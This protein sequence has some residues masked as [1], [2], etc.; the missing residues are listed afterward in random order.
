MAELSKKQPTAASE[1]NTKSLLDELTN[2]KREVYSNVDQALDCDQKLLKSSS[3][4]KYE[5]YENAI[6]LYQKSLSLTEKALNYYNIHKDKLSTENE[7]LQTVTKL[8]AIRSQAIERINTIRSSMNNLNASNLD[9]KF[10]EISDDVLLVDDFDDMIIAENEASATEAK[11][12]V[13]KLEDASKKPFDYVDSKRATELIRLENAARMFYIGTDG[14]VTTPSE[15]TSISLYSFEQN[16]GAGEGSIP[17]F[18][19]CGDWMYP[20]LANENPGM[21]TNFDAYIFPNNDSQL[22]G[23]IVNADAECTFVG[24]TFNKD[25][26][27]REQVT[28]FEDILKNFNALVYQDTTRSSDVKV[29]L[30]DG[31]SSVKPVVIDGA[32]KAPKEKGDG[33]A[34]KASNISSTWSADNIAG[35]LVTGAGYVSKGLSTGTEYAVKYMGLG[36]EK[37]KT[38]LQPNAVPSKVSPGVQKSVEVV[39]SGTNMTVRVS[40]YLV[41]KLGKLVTATAKASAPIIRKGT[42]SLLT[43][44]G[45]SSNKDSAS[46]TVEDIC[47]VGGGGIKGVVMVWESLEEAAITLGKNFTEQ[48]VTVVDHKYGEDAARVTEN[49]LYSAGNIAMTVNNYKGLKLKKVGKNLVK[50]A[51]KETIVLKKEEKMNETTNKN[52]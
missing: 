34:S 1:L 40:G 15:T 10:L 32:D 26:V 50:E 19:K 51:A 16:N 39:R 46:S 8:E 52:Q 36:G 47:K 42:T 7:A 29:P 2:L 37:L 17:G 22:N 12:S 13:A 35:G 48:T 21:K 28:F 30:F 31:K 49:G 14:S 23:H 38:S 44:T 24:V 3:K 25:A 43:S 5:D 33:S 20:L 4:V 6:Y 41:D 11:A 9:T 27:T 18:I 45:V